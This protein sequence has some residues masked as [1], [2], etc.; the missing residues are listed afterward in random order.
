M[1]DDPLILDERFRSNNPH[2]RQ[3]Y[4]ITNSS[5]Q[6]DGGGGAPDMKKQKKKFQRETKGGRAKRTNTL[7]P[8]LLPGSHRPGLG[9]PL[10]LPAFA[11]NGVKDN[12]QSVVRLPV[13]L[14]LV[15]LTAAAFVP[16]KSHSDL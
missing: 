12:T 4:L 7:P 1:R 13:E 16:E 3:R 8:H 11:A 5:Q 14:Y 2:S 9:N 10:F 15:A 6:G